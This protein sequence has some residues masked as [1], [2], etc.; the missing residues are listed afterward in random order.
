MREGPGVRVRGNGNIGPCTSEGRGVG[1][2]DA[3]YRERKTRVAERGERTP[4]RVSSPRLR[5]PH[6]P[7]FRRRRHLL[8][9]D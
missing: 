3:S 5:L 6:P 9:S 1:G 4:S 8:A 7:P 2:E